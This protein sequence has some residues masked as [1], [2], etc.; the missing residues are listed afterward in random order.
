MKS[1]FDFKQFLPL[2]EAILEEKSLKIDEVS[3]E[4]I[5]RTVINRVYYA[6][7]NHTREWLEVK[8]G[9]KTRVFDE[10]LGKMRN[11]KNKSSH[12]IVYEDLEDISNLVP[13]NLKKNFITLSSDLRAM[14]LKRIEADYNLYKTIN[15]QDVEKVIED[16]IN[17]MQLLN[18]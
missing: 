12:V 8:Y 1:Y 7:Y 16:G 14:F 6:C 13:K 17:L 18:F 2:A 5:Y 4:C 9:M 15:L 11:R 10:S 3:E